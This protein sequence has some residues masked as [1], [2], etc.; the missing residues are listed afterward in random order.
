MWENNNA[1]GVRYNFLVA[2]DEI[3]DFVKI[4]FIRAGYRKKIF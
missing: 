2:F 4:I 1:H 3:T